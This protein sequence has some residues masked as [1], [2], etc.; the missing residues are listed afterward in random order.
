MSHLSVIVTAFTCAPFV[1]A[2][3]DLTIRGA[4][5]NLVRAQELNLLRAMAV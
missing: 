4:F 3:V 2:A 5:E 1:P